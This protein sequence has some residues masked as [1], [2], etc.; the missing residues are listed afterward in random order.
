MAPP[1]LEGNSVA[2]PDAR[3]AL[4]RARERAAAAYPQAAALQREIGERMGERLAYIKHTPRVIL[5]AGSARGEDSLRL[6]AAYPQASVLALD[7]SIAMQ[8]LTFARRA[9]WQLRR[10]HGAALPLCAELETLPLAH[11]SVSMIWSN[12]ALFWHEAPRVAS[13]F[14]RVLEPQGLLMLATLGPDSLKELRRAYS[15]L[16]RD[17]H[18]LDFVDMHD[19]GDSLLHAGFADPVVDM[20]MLTLTYPDL[21]SLMRELRDCG[22]CTVCAPLRS[23]LMGRRRW[24]ALQDAYP[25]G[26]DGRIPATFEVIYAHAWKAAKRPARDVQVVKLD[27]LKR[28]RD[29]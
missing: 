12:L 4:R 16:D 3:R 26:A 22:S 24:Q 25:R 13:E 28:W 18:V 10:R 11:E 7:S 23:G 5:D 14:A 19:L 8:R 2:A 27:Q 17:Q 1:A 15:S 20:E 21:G 29:A 9:W 6:R